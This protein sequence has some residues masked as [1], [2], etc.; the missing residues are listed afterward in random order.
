MRQILAVFSLT[1]PLVYVSALRISTRLFTA[2]KDN[3]QVMNKYSRV[4]TEPPSQG[5]SQAMLYA[6]GLTPESIHKPQVGVC[7]VWFE[8]NPCNMHLLQLSEKVKASIEE[9]DLIGYRFNTIGVSDGISMGT[10]GMSYS[11]QSR[12]LIADSI[13]TTMGAQWYDGLVA[14]PGCD[15]NMPGCL[16]AMGRLNRPSIMVYGGTIRAG[17]TKK[18]PQLDIVSAF[19]SF[20]EK[21]YSRITE[22]ERREI[23]ENACPGPGACGGMYTANT[24]ATAIEALGMSLPYSSSIPAE[25][26]LN[27][28]ECALIGPAMENLLKHDIKPRDIMT[29]KSFE[30]AITVVLALG[31]STNAV[32]HLIAMA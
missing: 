13:E 10:D 32:L 18:F 27:G 16:I 8:G 7:S 20:G 28:M 3:D 24:M 29:K 11:L 2:M 5:A 21:I 23:V 15:K 14:I 19:Q 12:D 17:C 30:N 6:T 4:I 25:D 31:G 26:K 22:E 1:I 9:T